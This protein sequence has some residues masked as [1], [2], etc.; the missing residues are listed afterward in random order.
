MSH[1]YHDIP[2][3]YVIRNTATGDCYIGSTAKLARRLARHKWELRHGRHNNAAL[4]NAWLWHGED[5]FAFEVLEY[6]ENEADLMERE[7]AHLDTLAPRYNVLRLAYSPRGYRHTEEAKAA[8]RKAHADGRYEG[9][10][11]YMRTRVVS[12]ATRDACARTGKRSAEWMTGV[13]KSEEQRRKNGETQRQAEVN[14]RRV[15]ALQATTARRIIEREARLADPDLDPQERR[16][17]ERA[18]YM[19]EWQARKAAVH[20]SRE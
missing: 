7:Q 9:Q 1:R 14:T 12:Q 6:V 20:T 16:R 4:S 10:R 17:I 11:E 2:A 15:A 13:P 18:K 5:A 3:V 8:I 19:R